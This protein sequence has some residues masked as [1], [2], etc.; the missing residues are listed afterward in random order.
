MSHSSTE[1]AVIPLGDGLRMDGIQALDLWDL[2][3]DPTGIAK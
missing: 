3:E 1:S 2:M